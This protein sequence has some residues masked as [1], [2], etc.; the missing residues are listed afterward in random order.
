[1]AGKGLFLQTAK[2]CPVKFWYCY[3]PFFPDDRR[4]LVLCVEVPIGGI[5]RPQL[6][7]IWVEG[8]ERYRNPGEDLPVDFDE[9]R[10]GYY[11]D[12][13]QPRDPDRFIEFRQVLDEPGWLERMMPEDLR[14]LSPLIYHHVNPYA[15]FE[16]DMARRFTSTWARPYG[17]LD[18]TCILLRVGCLVGLSNQRVMVVGISL[19]NGVK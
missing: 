1:M 11:R 8:T 16:L 18:R 14:A 4:K 7:E 12:L 10:E 3:G 9:K 17:T 6:Q 13:Q 15:T 5:V 2:S 19:P